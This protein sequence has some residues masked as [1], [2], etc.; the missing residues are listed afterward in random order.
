MFANFDYPSHDAA[1]HGGGRARGRERARRARPAAQP[2]R[3]VR[4]QRGRP[5]GGDAR[6]RSRSSAAARCSASCCRA[7]VGGGGRRRAVRAVGAVGRRSAVP[8]DRGVANYYGVGALPATARGRSPRRRAVRRRVPGVRQRARRRAALERAAALARTAVHH[9]RWKAGVPR[10]AGAGWDFDDVRDHYLATAVRG[11]P[12]GA[13]QR[14][15]RALSGALARRQRRGDGRGVRRVAA[16]GLAVRAAALVLWL[17]DLVPGAG[18]GLLDHAA[19][20]GRLSPPAPGAGAGRG[21]EHRRGPGRRR[22]PRRQRRPGAAAARLRVA[23]YRDFEMP[24]RRGASGARARA[25]HLRRAATSRRCS[26]VRRRSWAYRFGPPAQD[27]D[28]VQPGTVRGDGAELVSQAFRFPAG[29]PPLAGSPDALG[30]R[31][32]IERLPGGGTALRVGSTRFAYGVR[33]AA[34]GFVPGDDA[35]GIE[36]G[37]ER[38]IPLAR[39]RAP[40]RRRCRR[41][42]AHG[43]QHARTAPDL[44]H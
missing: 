22:R 39:A 27:V 44:V 30:L 8:P 1:V 7:L 43:A 14:R 35:F 15:P 34:E 9:P 42:R 17:R 23:L 32:A 33:V 11:R 21:L 36:P 31:A 40:A 2:R 25:P 12:G 3:A 13:A 18:W 6:A 37:H 28:R 26:A 16:G 20:E 5:A 41:R 4:Q 24:R 10:D 38:L 29:R 19:A